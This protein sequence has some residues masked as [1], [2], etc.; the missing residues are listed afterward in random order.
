MSD[1]WSSP[2]TIRELVELASNYSA[3]AAVVLLC[4]PAAV[5]ATGLMHGRGRGGS[6]PWKYLYALL[7]YLVCVPGMF[8]AVLTGYMLFFTRENLLDVNF[9]IYFL[10]I[11]SMVVTLLLMRRQ[12]N[13]GEVPGFDRLAG[14]MTMIGA[15]FVIVFALSRT[16]L[17]L[18]FGGSIGAFLALA[19]FAFGL[20][21][22]GADALFRRRDEPRG[23]PPSRPF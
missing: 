16:R 1:A 4:I 10:P 20:L 3:A 2:S 22:W 8:A 18:V 13:F 19:A 21:K 9:L 6:A 5:L 14:L 11:I 12:V 23:S 7:V 15:A 17:W